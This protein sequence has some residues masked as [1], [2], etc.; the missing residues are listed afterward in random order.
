[1][2]PS[3]FKFSILLLLISFSSLK[4]IPQVVPP[5]PGDDPLDT[6]NK[7]VL[8]LKKNVPANSDSYKRGD[9]NPSNP[10]QQLK[11]RTSALRPEDNTSRATRLRN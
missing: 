4:V 3:I 9:D 2:K 11:K 6:I 8:T 1:M 5:D 7:A 10:N